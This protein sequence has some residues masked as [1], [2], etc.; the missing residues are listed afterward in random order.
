MPDVG[1]HHFLGPRFERVHI[2]P[3]YWYSSIFAVEGVLDGEISGA[4]GGKGYGQDRNVR[5]RQH[6]THKQRTQSP[7]Y[8]PL[9]ETIICQVFTIVAFHKDGSRQ[10]TRTRTRPTD[11]CKKPSC[12]CLISPRLPGYPICAKMYALHYLPFVP[13]L[14]CKISGDGSGDEAV[15]G[16]WGSILCRGRSGPPTGEAIVIHLKSSFL[17]RARSQ[18]M[19]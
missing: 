8:D 2:R 3:L 12:K 17:S 14:Q 4:G 13:S 18:G 6:S 10:S 15:T 5:E 7:W 19:I 9:P 11:L 16:G 1:N